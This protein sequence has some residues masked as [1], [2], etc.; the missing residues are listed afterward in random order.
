M[1]DLK[2]YDKY[3]QEILPG[4]ICVRSKRDKIE[5]VIY[6]GDT[7]GKTPNYGRFLSPEGNTTIKF[8]GVVF[9]FDPMGKRRNQSKEVKQLI[10]KYYTG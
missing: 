3:G 6:K 10:K 9:A 8:S 1:L 4:D 2:R 7:R 5:I